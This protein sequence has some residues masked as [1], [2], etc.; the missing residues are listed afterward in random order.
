MK[1]NIE[2]MS[3]ELFGH[4]ITWRPAKEILKR[5]IWIL[6]KKSLFKVLL[7]CLQK[8][9]SERSIGYLQKSYSKRFFDYLVTLKLAQEFFER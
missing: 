7:A 2:G 3:L 6:E 5:T 8:R 1:V 9:Y 4:P